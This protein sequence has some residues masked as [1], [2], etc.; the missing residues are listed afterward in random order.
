MIES[1]LATPLKRPT[2][3]EA[4]LE[5]MLVHCREVF[6]GH[7]T[8]LLWRHGAFLCRLHVGAELF[9]QAILDPLLRV[10]AGAEARTGGS[11]G[12]LG[13]SVGRLVSW[14]VGRLVGWSVGRLVGWS[15]G[16]LVGWSVGWLVGLAAQHPQLLSVR[17]L[18]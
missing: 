14:S 17:A 5:S 2:T 12:R 9:V 11:V 4:L 6:F 15:V 1:S 10:L 18:I 8:C 16:R 13:W 7:E 3:L